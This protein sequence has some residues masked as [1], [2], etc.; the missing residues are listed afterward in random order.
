MQAIMSDPE[1]VKEFLTETNEL[2]ENLD[3]DLVSLE[4]DPKNQD[5]LNRIFRAIHTI[6]GTS[7]F[8]GFDQ[9]VEIG[10]V[11]EDVLHMLRDGKRVVTPDVMDILLEAMDKIKLLVK[12]IQEDQIQPIDLSGSL[13]RP[14]SHQAGRA[15]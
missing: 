13:A 11:S 15:G 14:G 2:I 6:K 8:L 12:Q 4:T 10:H 5:L 1:L 9:L 3:N 7:S